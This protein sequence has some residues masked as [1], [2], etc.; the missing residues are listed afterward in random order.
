MIDAQNGGQSIDQTLAPGVYISTPG[1]LRKRVSRSSYNKVP[2]LLSFFFFCL[3]L[4]L[5]P[6]QPGR[7]GYAD[8]LSFVALLDRYKA[9]DGY[10]Q[11]NSFGACVV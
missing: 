4:P 7:T 2:L 9:Q 11:H 10:V 3:S 1:P 6:S 5:S 8:E